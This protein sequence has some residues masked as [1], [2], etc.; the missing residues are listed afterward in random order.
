MLNFG[1]SSVLISVLSCN[2][3]IIFIAVIFRHPSVIL[4]IGFRLLSVFLILTAV[5]FLFPFELPISTNLNFPEGI[6]RFIVFLRNHR[7]TVYDR[8][9]SIWNFMEMIWAIGFL[10][11][12]IRYLRNYY[13]LHKMIQ[14]CGHDVP[15]K[16]YT[17]L[18]DICDG[19]KV[20]NH[21]RI[22]RVPFIQGPMVC[23]FRDYYI[24]L[25]ES[26]VLKER[27]M[28]F[29]LHHETSHIFHHDLRTKFLIQMVCMMYWWNP[30]CF[31]LKRQ[32]NLL[33][34]SRVDQTVA[35]SDPETKADYMECLL[36]I[37]EQIYQNQQLKN[38][39]G[40]SFSSRRRSLLYDRFHLLIKND[41]TTAPRKSMYFLLVPV[42][43]V[44]LFS[45]LY[46]FEGYYIPSETEQLSESPTSEDTYIIRND[47]GTYDV[48]YNDI[49]LE[50][51]D[52]LTYYPNDCKIYSS[53][54]VYE[55]EKN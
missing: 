41:S 28:Y 48:Y 10:V 14:E 21:I 25:P 13:V 47:D 33:L 11:L 46:I 24:L 30:F 7:F 54:E 4:R 8:N 52:S 29:V 55:N 15:S 32:T 3:L 50:T 43:M 9:F 22:I 36:K 18:K 39:I 35:L 5:R 37:T 42:C 49:F 23:R 34:E 1:F 44:Y 51:T 26:L 12:L 2:L 6:S 45:F 19:R 27:E 16:Y 31:F 17:L 20:G 53:K 38:A 40:I